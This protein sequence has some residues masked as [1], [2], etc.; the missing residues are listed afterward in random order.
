[1]S[2]LDESGKSLSVDSLSHSC[3]VPSNAQST[4]NYQ[5]NPSDGGDQP[6]DHLDAVNLLPMPQDVVNKVS[7]LQDTTNILLN[8]Q[9]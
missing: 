6:P 3:D 1:M 4:V 7:P 2:A 8:N 9:K 5:S